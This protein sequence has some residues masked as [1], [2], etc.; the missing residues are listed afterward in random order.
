MNRHH[1]ASAVAP[2]GGILAALSCAHPSPPNAIPVTVPA[3]TPGRELVPANT[4]RAQPGRPVVPP[5]VARLAG[6]LPLRTTGVEAFLQEHPTS[7]GRGVLIAVLDGG[8]DP[9]LPGM[10]TTT[11]GSRKVIELRDFSDEGRV[12]L[13]PVE[14]RGDSVRLGDVTLKG[15]GRVARLAARP[16]YGG[17]LREADLGW[18]PAADANGD[19]DRSD[20]FPLIV[21]RASDGWFLVT[22]TDGDGSLET[23]RPVHDYAQGGETFAYG[24][25]PLTIAA[26]LSEQAG[27]PALDLVYDNSSHGTHVAGIAAGHDLFGVEGFNG[28]APGAQLVGLKIANNGWG[29][30]STSGSMIGAMEY[31]ARYA[32]RRSLPLV[33]NLSYGVGNQL[34]GRAAIDSLVNDF[35]QRHP[36]V[37]VVVS[38]GNDRPGLSTVGFPASSDLALSVCALVPGV[39]ART[40]DPSRAPAPD[41]LGW[42]SARGGELAKPDLCAPGVAFSN[43]PAW[44][45]GEEIAGGTSQAA[46]QV[47]GMAALLLSAA[48]EEGAGRPRAIDLKRALTATA[49]RVRGTTTLDEGYG[50][51]NLPAAYQWLHASHQAGVFLVRVRP[52]GG[53]TSRATGAYRRDG[54][55]SP[56]DTIQRFLVSTVGG[57]AAARLVLSSDAEWL[58]APAQV[59]LG[60]QPAEVSLVYDAAKLKAPGVYV[61]NVWARPASDTMAGP[62]F[63]LANTVVV[64]RTLEQP[65]TASR[66][67][68][69][70]GVDRFF[71]RIPEDA[72]GLRLS[73]RTTSGGASVLYLFEPSGQP[74]RSS[75][76][77]EATRSDSGATLTV[78]AEDLLP[79]VYEAV[80]VASPGE[81]AGY[82]I[83]AALPSVSVRAIGTGPSAVLL[84]RTPD[85]TQVRV[86]AVVS[87][88]VRDQELEGSGEPASVQLPIPPWATRMV[89]DLT[90][91]EDLWEQVTDVGVLVRD[92]SGQLL[93]DE[94][95]EYPRARHSIALDSVSRNGPITVSLFPAL[96]RG[97]GKA[98]WRAGIR[99]AF[100]RNVGVALDVLGM[101]KVGRLTL[102][103]HATMGLQFS[104]VPPEAAIPAGYAA[105]VDVVAAVPGSPVAQRQGAESSAGGAR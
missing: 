50:V 26:N 70:G 81:E 92:G 31:A 51:P 71:F 83:S 41:V 95:L 90:Y 64:P 38:A 20:R 37:L 104:P 48:A 100:L 57:Q 42:W 35:A 60:G 12:P 76:S 67:L 77:V 28:V 73:L 33:V 5:S 17:W 30:I 1:A 74:A 75:S 4:P 2:I 49:S 89:L 93:S 99:V 72:G 105:L 68:P 86:T 91:P 80:V 54:L 16:Y 56:S 53:N 82:R 103:P 55:A 69:A 22:D 45:M 102:L 13:E 59:E 9:G 10:R 98:T 52:D 96:A 78:P 84:N 58:R 34:E 25:G 62:A 85:T 14:P 97:A 47:A 66:T 23:E 19:G 11:T 87:G 27:H 39:F 61:G 65:F 40:P 21:A 43:V 36:D 44:R 3:A 18:G 79:G 46:P 6:L 101:G 32:A 63:R 88:A 24:S 8:I 15:F 29:K 7:D 94:P